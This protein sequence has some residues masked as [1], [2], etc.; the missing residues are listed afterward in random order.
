MKKTYA[1]IVAAIMLLI[2]IFI[3][4]PSDDVNKDI[5]SD[6]KM[7]AIYNN[8]DERNSCEYAM[9]QILAENAI[10]VFGSS[11]L[12]AA[13]DVAYPPVLF[14][15]GN[16]DFNM[17]LIGKGHTQSLHHA[18]N[19][20]ALSNDINE[21]KVVLIL[22]PQWF[23]ENH[24]SSEAYSSIFSERMYVEFL[25]NKKISKTL[26]TNI[27]NRVK[28]LLVEDAEQLE[29]IEKYEELYLN[30]SRKPLSYMEMNVYDE[31]MDYKQRFLYSKDLAEI[32]ANNTKNQRNSSKCIAENIDFDELL[33]KA[34]QAGMNACT[35][36]KFYIYDEYFDVYIKD[37]LETYKDS[38][39]G[40]NYSFSPEYDDLRLFLNVC[41]ET[42]IEPLI[43]NIPVNGRW[44]DWIG[45][46]KEDRETYYENVRSICSEYQVEM[47][48]F[49]DKEYEEYFLKDI[50]HLGWKGW[51]YLDEKVYKFYK[52][53]AE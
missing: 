14:Q 51:A 26:K 9:K 18:I 43:V 4:A 1:F 19:V 24:L 22:S 11:E 46:S 44:Y 15:N 3:F 52:N 10:P 12:S 16:S 34:E 8:V 6:N 47:A 38:S 25:K 40:E 45:F 48:D 37:G 49:S 36:N 13:D 39:V 33:Y 29:R 30:Y 21:K 23:T 42:E 41:K 28:N 50:M 7:S 20:G 35:N 17:V 32:A 5:I 53:E 27:T 31:F 2:S